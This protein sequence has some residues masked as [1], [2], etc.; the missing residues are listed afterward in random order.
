MKEPYSFMFFDISTGLNIREFQKNEKK[1]ISPM[2]KT[3]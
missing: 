2:S 3:V 1:K